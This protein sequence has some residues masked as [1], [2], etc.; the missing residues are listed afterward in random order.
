VEVKIGT[1]GKLRPSVGDFLEKHSLAKI[2]IIVDTHSS[3]DGQIITQV[4][5]DW[6]SSEILGKVRENISRSQAQPMAD[7]ILGSPGQPSYPDLE[8]HRCKFPGRAQACS[9]CHEHDVWGVN[10]Q[11]E[12]QGNDFVPVALFFLLIPARV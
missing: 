2:V 11:Q 1:K 9:I 8:H 7:R 4:T 12:D 10:S 6:V 5:P 3:Q